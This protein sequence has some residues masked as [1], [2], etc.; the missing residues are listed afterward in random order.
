MRSE[1]D[2]FVHIEHGL[3]TLINKFHRQINDHVILLHKDEL[4]ALP[5]ED[6]RSL[7]HKWVQRLS[8]ARLE[9]VTRHDASSPGGAD[10]EATPRGDR[11]ICSEF[12]DGLEQS[13]VVMAAAIGCSEC[14]HPG[15]DN[16]VA[17]KNVCGFLRRNWS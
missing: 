1:V 9:C 2:G 10:G 4:T 3:V 13:D 8:R 7:L 17:R 14:L 12:A 5:K 11:G 15:V 16:E 6:R